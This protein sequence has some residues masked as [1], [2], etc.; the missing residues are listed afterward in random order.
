MQNVEPAISRRFEWRERVRLKYGHGDQAAGDDG[1]FLKQRGV[2]G[3]SARRPGQNVN[4]VGVQFMFLPDVCDNCGDQF[5]GRILHA[6]DLVGLNRP[7]NPLLRIPNLRDG[8]RENDVV[9]G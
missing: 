8:L 5:F 9:V 1:L 7:D 6:I 4:S 2:S 3:R